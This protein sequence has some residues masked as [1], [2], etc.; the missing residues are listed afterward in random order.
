MCT[1]KEMELACGI[2]K[3]YAVT[4]VNVFKEQSSLQKMIKECFNFK[5]D[6]KNCLQNMCKSCISDVRAAYR[7]KRNF[8]RN[9]DEKGKDLDDIV[10]S[11]PSEDW[12]LITLIVKQERKEA[13]DEE[14][15]AKESNENRGTKRAIESPEDAPAA[16]KKKPTVS[17]LERLNRDLTIDINRSYTEQEA[18]THS[19]EICQNTFSSKRELTKHLSS[20]NLQES[21]LK[22]P[23]CLKCFIYDKNF[24]KHLQVH[25]GELELKCSYCPKKF[26]RNYDLM[27][28]ALK[29]NYVIDTKIAENLSVKSHESQM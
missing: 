11:L 15:S 1:T 12:D 29:H 20:H 4:L 5:V 24:Q 16:K 21:N 2:C 23:Y 27:R 22:C 25:S 13:S 18:N 8:E 9:V 28:H 17:A 3:S 7:F 10:D 14:Q 6:N 19:C 26:Q